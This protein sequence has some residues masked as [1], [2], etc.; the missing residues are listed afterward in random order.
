MLRVQTIFAKDQAEAEHQRQQNERRGWEHERKEFEKQRRDW[1]NERRGWEAKQA[2]WETEKKGLERRLELALQ[3]E[4]RCRSQRS[5]EDGT[6]GDGQRKS[7]TKIL[8]VMVLPLQSVTESVAS[9]NVLLYGLMTGT[10]ETSQSL[11]NVVW[12]ATKGMVSYVVKLQ[13][14]VLR[15]KGGLITGPQP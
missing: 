7:Y 8:P 13:K 9:T 14:D 1:E 12:V 3:R 10:Y 15:M 4:Q 6:D 2:E 11:R 5:S